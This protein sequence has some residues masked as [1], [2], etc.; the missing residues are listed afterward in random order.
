MAFYCLAHPIYLVRKFS[1]KPNFTTLCWCILKDI[2]YIYIYISQYD[3]Y[4]M[5]IT[6][7]D[8]TQFFCWI[9][10]LVA[11]PWINDSWWV[12]VYNWVRRV[13]WMIEVNDDGW[14]G[15]VWSYEQLESHQWTF[16]ILKPKKRRKMLIAIIDRA[17]TTQHDWDPFLKGVVVTRVLFCFNFVMK[18]LKWQLFRSWFS[19]IWQ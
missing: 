8:V 14:I 15:L 7:M 13:W 5:T 17:P 9:M 18:L 3:I 19:W 6:V 1:R 2:T 10:Q 16:R 4:A 11:W 12:E